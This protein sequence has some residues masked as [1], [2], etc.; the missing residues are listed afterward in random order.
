VQETRRERQAVG[1]AAAKGGW[2]L[3]WREAQEA[4]NPIVWVPCISRQS[5]PIAHT[6]WGSVAMRTE[7]YVLTGH[8]SAR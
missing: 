2:R 5:L 6:L 8:P 4:W 7:D 1:I 3:F